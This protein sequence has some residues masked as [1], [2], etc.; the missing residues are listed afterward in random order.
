MN[1][2]RI[3][4]GIGF[5]IALISTACGTN[6]PTYTKGAEL[7]YYNFSQPATFEEGAYRDATLRV[8]D[9]VYR[10]DVPEG[11]GT[12][13]W[14]QWGDTYSDVIVEADVEQMTERNE[15]AFG[16]MC[17]VRGNTGIPAQVDPTLQAMMQETSEA[18]FIDPAT[19][20][21]TSEA[22]IDA[23]ATEQAQSTPDATV[24]SDATDEA[25]EASTSEA[26]IEAAETDEVDAT[27]EAD[28]IATE[29][30]T[31]EVTESATAEATT[32]AD[33]TPEVTAEP[34]I[35]PRLLLEG[36]G[37]LF[38]IQG[39]GAGGIFRARGRDFQPLVDWITNEAIV[40]G[41]GENHIRAICA[42]T[43][44]LL[45][46]NDVLVA[47]ATDD[48]YAQGQIGLVAGASNSLGLRVEFDNV[49]ISAVNGN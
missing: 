43:D 46:V 49:Q 17:R 14:G 11:D 48:A 10:I 28:A 47:Q 33:A 7:A 18:S 8:V 5:F 31:A 12:L 40:L 35:D 37:Y 41:P 38:L 16:V 26:T 6:A 22:T 1:K 34:T 15:N 13:W 44:L 20:E 2:R 30:S 23:A 36:D 32:S 4:I 39:T 25:T 29:E 21:P 27:I 24:E 19:D 3:F 45:Y 9:G 42:G